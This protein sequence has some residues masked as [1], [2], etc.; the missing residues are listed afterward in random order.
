M[1]AAMTT[2][3]L[4]HCIVLFLFSFK[5]ATVFP[6]R[7][8]WD[9]EQ[10]TH[11]FKE[12]TRSLLREWYL[13]GNFIPF[14]LDLLKYCLIQKFRPVPKSEQEAGAGAG[15][16]ADANAGEFILYDFV[17]SKICFIVRGAF[18]NL[19][20]C[21]SQLNHYPKFSLKNSSCSSFSSF[22]SSCQQRQLNR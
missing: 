3:V 13:Q 10:K 17:T 9:G 22:F 16:W 6:L 19:A 18:K 20:F 1:L 5:D 8:I 14:S 12:R 4:R 7:T 15:N 21:Y 2:H 11:C